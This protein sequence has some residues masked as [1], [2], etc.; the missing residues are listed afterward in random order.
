VSIRM[1]SL[2]AKNDPGEVSLSGTI[3][4]AE[5]EV[6]RDLTRNEIDHGVGLID[7]AAPVVPG[8]AGP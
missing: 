3:P 1:R 6:E 8:Q 5:T 2:G 7:G 4:L